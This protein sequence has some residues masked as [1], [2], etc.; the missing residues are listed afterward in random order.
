M[1]SALIIGDGPGGLS[2]AL[3]LAKNEIQTTVFGQNETPMHYAMLYNYLGIPEMTGTEFQEVARQQITGFGANL[4]ETQVKTVT[5][6]DDGFSVMTS[7][8]EHYS[9][10]YLVIAT[11][12]SRELAESLGLKKGEEG[13]IAA[14]RE[15][16]TT[17]ENL[18]VVGRTTRPHQ[19][20]AIISAGDGASAALL[21]LSKE[22]KEGRRY[23][24]WDEVPSD[25]N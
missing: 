2:A 11:G 22:K 6:N 9:G 24:D 19:V 23:C 12:S 18:F 17:V 13:E 10:K 14:S 21:I 20:Q 5:K 4:V 15:A 16:E 1:S 25:N 7:E 8:G 3:Y